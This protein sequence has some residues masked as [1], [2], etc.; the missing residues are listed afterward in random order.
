MN[1]LFERYTASLLRPM[2]RRQGLRLV[3]QGPRRYLGYDETGRGR[4]LMRPDIA[5]L[6][7]DGVP[8]AILDTKWKRIEAEEPMAGL[9]HA[10]LYQMSSYATTYRC[11]NVGL[12]YPE[13]NRLRS[14]EHH[15]LQLDGQFQAVLALE[16]VP[17]ESRQW[18]LSPAITDRH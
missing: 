9:S 5:L 10:D 3:E 18:D 15:H 13:Q 2:A 7:Q 1:H 14:G 11:R 4:L 16:A 8:V 6:D 12:L 17:M